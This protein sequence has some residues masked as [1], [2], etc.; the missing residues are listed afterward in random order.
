MRWIALI[1]FGG[2]GAAALWFGVSWGVARYKLVSSG[3]P[4][5]GVIVEHAEHRQEG[6]AND[7]GD[8]GSTYSPIVEFE[9]ALGERIRVQGTTGTLNRP[10]DAVGTP[11]NVIYDPAN[12]SDAVITEFKQAW[13]GPLALSIFGTVFLLFGVGGFIGMRD[14]GVRVPSFEEGKAQMER[15]EE[16]ARQRER[17]R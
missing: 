9:T 13:L 7:D 6:S 14:D 5:T 17:F 10:N 3:V 8:G 15:A 16:D 12:P 11:A 2:V 4:A 1:L